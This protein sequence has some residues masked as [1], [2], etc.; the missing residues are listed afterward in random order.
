M[1]EAKRKLLLWKKDNV[2]YMDGVAY[3]Y[4]DFQT[5]I[6]QLLLGGA[7]FSLS[8]ERK[9]EFERALA[10]G[11]IQIGD[12]G[13]NHNAN[14]DISCVP[15]QDINDDEYF[16]N[17]LVR[18]KDIRFDYN[19][20]TPEKRRILNHYGYHC[21]IESIRPL[22]IPEL[23]IIHNTL[24]LNNNILDIDFVFNLFGS[25]CCSTND[26][27]SYDETTASLIA[28]TE[29][30]QDKRE[31]TFLGFN[32]CK[33]FDAK[34]AKLMLETYENI[35]RAAYKITTALTGCKLYIKDNPKLDFVSAF[36]TSRNIVNDDVIMKKV[37]EPTITLSELFEM[38]ISDSVSEYSKEAKLLFKHYNQISGSRFPFELLHDP[39]I[40]VVKAMI[41]N[42]KPEYF[43]DI[44]NCMV[45]RDKGDGYMLSILLWGNSATVYHMLEDNMQAF[46]KLSKNKE[47]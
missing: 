40:I 1:A 39:E 21:K 30:H 26:F 28:N 8:N 45:W 46:I 7:W 10:N 15:F 9:K 18:K 38:A 4:E 37:S 41:E 23:E 14:K 11:K 6:K 3:Q 16:I 13:T 36:M 29:M 35:A 44:S 34:M 19:K 33:V 5:I 25:L 24:K 12:V 27:I 32:T 20:M 42:F 2:S 22:N 17:E 31:R 43:D 47:E